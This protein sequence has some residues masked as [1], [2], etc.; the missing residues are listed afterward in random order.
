MNKP[1]A[2]DMSYWHAD[3]L[4]YNDKRVLAQIAL[5]LPRNAKVRQVVREVNKAMYP[6]APKMVRKA[7]IRYAIRFYRILE[8]ERNQSTTS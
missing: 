8:S 2:R 1:P 4:S 7:A 5:S 6:L 3:K